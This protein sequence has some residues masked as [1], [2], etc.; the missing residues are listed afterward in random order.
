MKS[1]V[2]A[3]VIGG[4]VVGCSVLYH[5]AKAGWT[6]IMLIERSELTSGSSWHAAGGFHTLNGDPNVA[7]L[8]AYTVQLYKEIEELSGQSCSL[9]LTGGVMMA[10]TPERMDFL[11]LAHAKGRYLGMDTELITP[12]EAKAMFPLMDEKNFVGAMWDPVEGHLDPSGTTIA[13]SKAAKKLGAEIVL[14]NR[15]VDLTQQ[16]DGTWNVVTEQGTVHAEHVVN[17]GGLWAREI[18]RMVGVELPVLAMEHMYLLTEPMPEV[19][20]FNKSTGREMIGV[21]D[22]KGE[23]YTRQERNGVLLGTYEKACKP[24]SPVNTPWDFGHELLQPDIDRIAPSLEIGFKHF[25]GIEKAGIKQIINGPFTFAL[26]GNPLVGPVQGLT[27][28]W[29]A[30][31]VMAGF[32]Q[33][34][35]VGLALSNWMVHGDPGFDVWGMDVA[36]FG[37]WASLRYTNAKVRENYSR[38]FSIRFPNE[39]L[40]AARP[41]QTTPLYDTMLANNAVMG[42]SWGLETP[43]WFAPKG[44]EPKDIVSF[45][46]SNDFGPIGEEVRA[47]REKVGVTE[48]ANFAKY[49]VSGPGAE[50]FL[51]RLMTNRMPKIGRIVLT[52]MVNEFGKLIGDFTIAKAGPRNGEDRFMIWGSSAAQ[53]YH[54]RWFEKH[55]PKD[56]SVRIHRFDQTLVGLS[57]A[58]PKSRDL[59]EKLVDVDVSTKAFRFMDFREMAV[60]GAP[61]MVNRITYTGDL[62]YEIWM[63][64]A[65]QRLVYK[66]IKDAGA[67]FGIVDFGMR[68]LLSMRLEKN[69]P[70]WFRELRPIYGPFEGSMDR[71]IKL[72]KNDFIGREAS[73]REHAEGPKLRRVSFIVDA[74]DADVMGDEPIWAKVGKDYGT[75]EKPHGYGAPRFDEGGKEV[76]GSKAAEGAS[77]VRGIVDGEWRVVGWVTSGGYAHYVQKSMAQGYVPAALAEDESAGLFEIEI[78]GHRRPARINIEPPFDPSGEKM[79]T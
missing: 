21:L 41:A 43:L 6:D 63:A 53:K 49:E 46:R 37:E 31:A 17:C 34:G 10:D 61:C 39:E 58:G 72:E 44:T 74:A 14:R 24:W 27:N 68:A 15:V 78:L 70:T 32:S 35:G 36:R 33:G 8:Q 76:R 20:E 42:D 73:A 56:G 52:P 54:M 22:F 38:R 62:G 45:H 75:V 51:N 13:Y 50:D 23:I 67:E 12:S 28:F 19:E 69:F 2:K 40:P 47:T 48:I 66:A 55:L 5:L 26:D 25:P 59:L 64:P 11:R 30:C 65:Y 29:C 4:G 1:H 57:I 77:A 60:G 18:G 9:H 7:K 16:P 71:F 79:R 3:V